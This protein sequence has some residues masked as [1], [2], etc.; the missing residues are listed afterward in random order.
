MDA[1]AAVIVHEELSASDPGFCLAYLAHAILFVNNSDA[2]RQ[3]GAA[4]ALLAAGAISGSCRLRHGH[5]RA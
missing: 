1:L 2:Q 3:R 5:V 4:R